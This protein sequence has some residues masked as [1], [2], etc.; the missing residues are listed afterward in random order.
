MK[1]VLKFLLSPVFLSLIGVIA[2]S[3]LVWYLGPLFGISGA[4]PLASVMNRWLLIG[5]LFSAWAVFHLGA[6]LLERANNQRLLEQ[7]ATESEPD[8]AELAASDELRTLRERFA[9]AL[10]TLKQSDGKRQFGGRWVYQLPWYLIIGPPGCGKTTALVNSGLRFPLAAQ[11]GQDAI[12]GIGGTRNCDWWFTDEAILIDTAGRYTTQDS[13]EQVDRA[14]WQN[15]LALLKQ[16]RPRRPINGV[17]VALS[18]SDL[19]QQTPA[20]RTAHAQAIRQRVRELGQTFGIAVPVYVLLMKTDLI[21]GFSEFFA[22]LG[23][24]GREQVWGVTFELDRRADAPNPLAVLTNELTTLYARLEQRLLARLEQEREPS[25]RALI[26]NFPRQFGALSETLQSFLDEAFMP[27]R[28]ET[29]PLVRGV[30]FTSGTQEG[31]PI[32]RILGAFAVS[33]GLSRHGPAPFQGTGKSYFITRLLRA[34]IFQES[35]IAGV[36]P[37]LEHRRLWQRRSA[38]AGVALVFLAAAAAWTNS[39]SRNLAY[40]NAVEQ[41]A[42]DIEARIESLIPA[43]RDPF[44]LLPL[45]DAARA[46]P[47]GFAEREAAVPVSMGLGL[48][49]G[50]KL[51]SQAE[52]AYR[53]M[54][55]KALLPR[56]ILRLEEQIRSAIQ[57][58]PDTLH[59]LLKVYLMLGSEEH[60]DA[61]VVRSQIE[62]D[63]ESRLPRTA[64]AE[65]KASLRAHLDAL[66]AQRP[67]PLP[68]DLDATLISR[69]QELLTRTSAADRVYRQ[70]KAMDLGRELRD[71]TLS[72]AG[73]DYL[74]LVFVRH[75]GRA[76]NQGIPALYTY[77]GYYQAFTKNTEQLISQLAADSWVLG[78]EASLQADSEAAQ[79]LFA[80]V[81]ERYFKEYVDLW[82]D[83]LQDIEPISVRDVQ[84]AAEVARL[85]SDKATSPLRQLLLAVTSQ[86]QLDRPPAPDATAAD[87]EQ[88]PSASAQGNH[89]EAVPES[90]VSRR[91]SWLHDLVRTDDQGQ[92]PLDAALMTLGKLQLTLNAIAAAK[93]SGHTQLAAGQTAGIQEAQTLAAQLPGPLSQV[94][95]TLAQDSANLVANGLR[96]Q[97]NNLWTAEILPLCREAIYDRY[98]FARESEAETTLIDFV[99]L[100]GPGGLLDTFFKEHLSQFVDTTHATWRWTDPNL[101]IPAP[102]LAQFQRAAAIRDAFFGKN[103][104]PAIEF[105]LKPVRMDARA[106][107][108]ILDLGGQLLDYRQGPP[109]SQR[110]KWPAADGAE[111][112]RL[113]FADITGNSP[114][115][116]EE[117]S[118]AWFRI[119]E[120]AGLRPTRQPERFQVDFALGDLSAQF[121]LRALSVRNPFRL[122]AVRAFRCP[123]RL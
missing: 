111:W 93:A 4:H 3:C 89:V 47:G 115:V 87:A 49:Q 102:V 80:A 35:G 14:A 54:L 30:Y 59:D 33:L 10:S 103:P 1:S 46:I 108:F 82:N 101:G 73:G 112:V 85:L 123:E 62:R 36:D 84:Q 92:A 74:N 39:Y 43:E 78:P 52:H 26:F 63:W 22:D 12:H 6:A 5:G 2:L 11:L 94:V 51:G 64:T 17:L 67:T 109:R 34:V 8:P 13:Y 7:L 104:L 28:F 122:D 76:L 90:Y 95:G 60:Y 120:R 40:I 25:K 113:S 53:R 77:D 70:L 114:S 37:R 121:E 45:L 118:W 91:F 19:M 9:Q 32:D 44:G 119:L 81:R 98:P 18:L 29:R 68:L 48:Y 31:T 110:L 83:L 88:A 99:Q 72:A 75:S 16:H 55:N 65:Q 15:F 57:T 97:L 20:E 116:T 71:F 107:Q 61:A 69:A 38:Y 56:V 105:E 27:S 100:F 58:E 21:A 96:S 42:A 66:L 23:R 50:D 79:Q 117:G 24:E 41:H 86:T 106:T